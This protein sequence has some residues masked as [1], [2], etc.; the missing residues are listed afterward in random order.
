MT[1]GRPGAPGRGAPPQPI[2][3]VCIYVIIY[4][5][6]YYYY[7]YYVII[8]SLIYIYIYIYIYIVSI[9]SLF[10]DDDIFSLVIYCDDIFALDEARVII[11]LMVSTVDIYT[12][13]PI[14]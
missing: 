8:Y 14:I 10:I 4:S 9:Y 3:I 7:Y 6:F 2:F 1:P 5:L 13:T 12:Y 11:V